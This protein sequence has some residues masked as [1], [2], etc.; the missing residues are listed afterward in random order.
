MPVRMAK[1]EEGAAAQAERL[2]SLRREARM[3]AAQ[4]KQDATVVAAGPESAAAAVEHAGARI[5]PV[6]QS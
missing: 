5:A 3:K 1:N 6:V 2:A 4:P